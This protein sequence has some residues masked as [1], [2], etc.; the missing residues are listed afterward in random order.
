MSISNG[1]ALPNTFVNGQ[2]T[3]APSMMA[4]LNTLLVGLNRALLD[5]GSGLGMNA[6]ATQIHNVS[7]PSAAQDAATQ[8]YVTLQLASYPTSAYLAT[9]LAG[10]ATT[11]ALALRAPL[12]SPAFTAIPTAPTPAAGTNTTQIATTAFMTAALAALGI[13]VGTVVKLFTVGSINTGSNITSTPVTFPT[14]FPNSCVGAVAMALNAASSSWHAVVL[15]A[16]PSTLT[17]TGFTLV[18]DTANAASTITNT[19]PV[20]IIAW[21]T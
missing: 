5:T 7:D 8:N 16:Q 13:P 19:V 12:A 18:A 9:T 10:Y 4:D 2:A 11:T 20:A 17:V 6:Q 21:G 14:P 3:D 15:A 1:L